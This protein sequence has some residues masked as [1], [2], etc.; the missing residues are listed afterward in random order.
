MSNWKVIQFIFKCLC[1]IATC[2][3]LVLWVHTYLLDK[4]VSV[5]E[6]RSY[7]DTEDDVFPVMSICFKQSFDDKHF[8]KFGQNITG[9][10]YQK[11][12]LG[13][14]FDKDMEKVDYDSVTTNISEFIISYNVEFANGSSI[15]DTNSNVAWKHPYPTYTW[16]SFQH[17]VKCF[18][19]EITNKNVYFLRL[20][21][22]RDVFPD[23]IRPQS[24]GFAV[25]FHYPNQLTASIHSVMRHWTPRDNMSN[26][27]MSFNI[28]GME[29]AVNRYKYRYN[30][31][32]QD[33]K[34][35]DDVVL[36][37]HLMSVGCKTPYQPTNIEH[38][39]SYR[40]PLCTSKAKMKEARLRL[41]YSGGNRPCREIE[42]ISVLERDADKGLTTLKKRGKDWKNWFGFVLRILNPRFK[43]IIQK[44][45]VDLQTLV[46][47]VGGYIGIF[48]GFALAQIP[49]ILLFILKLVKR[50]FPRIDDNLI[51]VRSI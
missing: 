2:A 16:L 23:R 47:Y 30:N 9:L 15:L 37:E 6:G 45:E 40:W 18:G 27:L 29:A 1:I 10:N 35:Y 49:D 19:L 28:K 12:L 11:Y 31:C 13:E 7:Y 22:K 8:E 26:Y 39:P 44:K 33:W 51:E 41:K 36:K 14:Y 5:I 48:T 46:G 3:L 38:R 25:L 32:V 24:G 42:A 21:M 43:I 50:W 17:I 20:Y 34:N 4:D